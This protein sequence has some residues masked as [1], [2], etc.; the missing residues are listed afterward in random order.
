[1]PLEI[2]QLPEV[3]RLIA[4]QEERDSRPAQ[5]SLSITFL[6]NFTIEP[7]EPFLRYRFGTFA[8]DPK[9]NFGGY[10]DFAGPA[11]TELL[12]SN[13][14]LL[15]VTLMLEELI[16]D[17]EITPWSINDVAIRIIEILNAVAAKC[18]SLIVFNTLLLPV[19]G[20][21]GVLTPTINNSLA[22]RIAGVNAALCECAKQNA[23]RMLIIDWNRL[24]ALIGQP[25]T[26]DMRFGYL[27]RAYLKSEFLDLFS[28]ELA[29]IAAIRLGKSKKCLVLDCDD[30]LWGG[31]I[32]EEGINGIALDKNTYPGRAFYDFQKSVLRL[33]ERGVIVA[34]CSKNNEADVM[35]VLDSHPACVLK[36]NHLA[37]WQINWDDKVANIQKIAK[38]L[39][40]GLDSFV[41][42]DNSPFEIAR[43]KEALPQVT[44]R[45]VPEALYHYRD[46]LLEEG[47]FDTL[48]LTAEDALRNAT[49]RADA[50]R[51]A[52]RREVPSEEEY[53]AAL[54]LKISVHA[55]SQFEAPRVAQLTQ[56]TNQFNLTTRRYSEEE[57]LSF[58]RNPNTLVCSLH[59][60]DRFSDYGITGVCIMVREGTTFR[61]D[62]FLMSCRILGRK[63]EYAFLRECVTLAQTQWGRGA[64]VAEFI[65]TSRNAQ[66]ATFYDSCGFVPTVTSSNATRYTAEFDAVARVA[67]PWIEVEQDVRGAQKTNV[68]GL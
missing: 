3:L 44:V 33:V 22:E 60:R 67:T 40:V 51:E 2:K 5:T 10:G 63:I 26:L 4:E 13:P 55:V 38:K 7:I 66:V 65:P 25:R 56:K 15:C 62:S 19:F 61:V 24:R 14:Q 37:T 23:S 30:T 31:I 6:R 11:T 52:L 8:L 9:V 32:G 43:V 27:S 64:W 45:Q 58:A 17:Y 34:L 42:V 29:K 50:D 49:Y 47:L 59:A 57:I 12:R 54:E 1:M 68:A 28:S 46:L 20:E 53:L 35:D 36:R 39:N 41:F 16:A 48:T 18:T 21:F